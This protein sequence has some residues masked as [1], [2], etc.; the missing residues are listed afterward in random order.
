M[1]KAVE[2]SFASLFSSDSHTL[3]YM[4]FD[5]FIRQSKDARII[6]NTKGAS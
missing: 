2:M 4:R 1:R 5:N 3:D 6:K